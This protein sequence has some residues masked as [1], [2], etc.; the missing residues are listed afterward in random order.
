MVETEDWIHSLAAQKASLL[1]T[2]V[3][4]VRCTKKI[5]GVRRWKTQR[6]CALD[7]ASNNQSETGIKRKC[8]LDE[9]KYFSV[10]DYVEH[11]MHNILEGTGPFDVKLGLAHLVAEGHV[12]NWLILF[13][14]FLIAINI[15]YR[16]DMN[17]NGA[18]RQTADQMRFFLRFFAK[19]QKGTN[20]G[21]CCC[22]FCHA[23]TLF[24]PPPSQQR[25]PYLKHLIVEHHTVFLP[26]STTWNP[27]T[28]SS[29]NQEPFGRMVH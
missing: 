4:G 18:M 12:S 24:S 16:D 15:L 19:Y 22:F 7:L 2:A 1:T 28:F 13:M 8:A 9:L 3:A 11:I 14:D 5:C 27:N 20:I 26:I 10:V 6:C 17:F 25:S 23:W 21:D 29:I